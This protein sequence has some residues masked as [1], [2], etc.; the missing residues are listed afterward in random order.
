MTIK[1]VMPMSTSIT[2][3]FMICSA[4]TIIAMMRVLTNIVEHETD[5]HD[6]R[7]QLKDAQYQRELREAQIRGLVPVVGEEGTGSKD[8]PMNAEDAIDQAQAAASHVA[9]ALEDTDL[10]SPPPAQAA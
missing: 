10:S 1:N 6:L 2:L 3:V 4:I 9:E 5:L 8:G 7:N